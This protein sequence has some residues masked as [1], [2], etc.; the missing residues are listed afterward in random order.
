MEIEGG[1]PGPQHSDGF[2]PSSFL[3]SPWTHIDA[4]AGAIGPRGSTR[5]GERQGSAYRARVIASSLIPV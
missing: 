5:L 3:G 1:L 2:E 4:L